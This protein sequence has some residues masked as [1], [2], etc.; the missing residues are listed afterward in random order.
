MAIDVYI[1]PLIE[2]S[3][4]FGYDTFSSVDG[5]RSSFRYRRV[6]QARHDRRAVIAESRRVPHTRV[7]VCE[8]LAEF[9]R[10]VSSA[11]KRIGDGDPDGTPSREP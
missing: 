5:R 8:T 10:S 11:T 4:G 3:G 2:R 9:E 7:H 1:G 6:E